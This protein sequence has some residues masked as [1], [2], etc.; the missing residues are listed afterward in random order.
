[1]KFDLLLKRLFALLYLSSPVCFFMTRLKQLSFYIEFREVFKSVV[2][3]FVALS[4]CM[5][6]CTLVCMDVVWRET[7]R[8]SLV[9]SDN[10]LFMPKRRHI[11]VGWHSCCFVQKLLWK[12]WNIKRVETH[13]WKEMCPQLL[14][15]GDINISVLL[16]I[17][18]EF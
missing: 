14:V 7:E 1:M 5:C 3:T 12:C 10:L 2:C 18:T 8:V 16:C 15:N 6:V 9:R 4:L 11:E 17:L 13:V